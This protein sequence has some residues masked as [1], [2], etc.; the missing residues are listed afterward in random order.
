MGIWVAIKWASYIAAG[1]AFI[2]GAYALVNGAFIVDKDEVVEANRSGGLL[3]IGMMFWFGAM[4]I[5]LQV[6]L[7]DARDTIKQ[8]RGRPGSTK[9]DDGRV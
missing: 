1:A 7:M 4:T 5:Y 3:I 8:L 6:R 9:Q 2:M